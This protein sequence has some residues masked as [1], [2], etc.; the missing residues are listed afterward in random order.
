M[1][2]VDTVYHLASAEQ[3]GSRADLLHVDITGSQMVSRAAA[4]A[5]VERFFYLSH[6]GAD[7]ASAY[8]ILK[9]KAIA[10]SHIRQSGVNYTILRSGLVFGLGDHFSTGLTALLHA[11]PGIFFIPDHG[12]TLIQ[13]I[14]VE[15]LVTC[16]TWALDLPDTQKQIISVGGAEILTFREIVESVK[17]IIGLKRLLISLS[18]AYMRAMTVWSE[19]LFPHFP[20]SIFWLDYIAADR[21]CAVD[22]VPRVFGLLPARFSQRLEHLK[23]QPWQSN[24]LRLLLQRQTR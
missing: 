17:R 9:A 10:E 15:D 13:P 19:H 22:T 20:V 14:W 1:K 5:G 23:E 7:R 12:R 24:L 2:G 6:L 18:P 11:L 21:T 3:R 4:D 8:P 16:L